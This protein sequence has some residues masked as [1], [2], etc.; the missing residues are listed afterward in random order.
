M[1]S[2]LTPLKKLGYSFADRQFT[3]RKTKST[4]RITN[5]LILKKL[6]YFNV[7]SFR[8]ENHRLFI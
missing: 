8:S 2:G 6:R 1:P 7:S 5:P 3:D 4:D